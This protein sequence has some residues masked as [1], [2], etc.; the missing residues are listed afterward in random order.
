MYSSVI[1]EF[2]EGVGVSCIQN[3]VYIFKWGERKKVVSTVKCQKHEW[4]NSLETN[5]F[6][7]HKT[8]FYGRLYNINA[9]FDLYE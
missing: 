5:K 9:I 3:Y 8:N 4:A 2:I 6:Y 1:Y 7:M